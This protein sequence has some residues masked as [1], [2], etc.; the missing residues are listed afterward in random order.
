MWR[1]ILP[2]IFHYRNLT[3]VVNDVLVQ[4]EFNIPYAHFT[5]N[6]TQHTELVY[7]TKST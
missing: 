1:L 2:R 7:I 6:E 3:I 5:L 4:N